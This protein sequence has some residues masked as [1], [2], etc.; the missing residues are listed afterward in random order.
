[1]VCSLRTCFVYLFE[2]LDV[3]IWL[4]SM[5]LCNKVPEGCGK[6]R[7]LNPMKNGL[8]MDGLVSPL[9]TKWRYLWLIHGLKNSVKS[10]VI[11]GLETNS[12][13]KNV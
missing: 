1:M 3:Q 9:S 5:S 4:F 8:N 2:E 13:L 10:V 12:E 11:Y 7:D 6:P